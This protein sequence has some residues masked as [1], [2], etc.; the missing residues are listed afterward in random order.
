VRDN[1]YDVLIIGA[2]LSGI[3]AACHLA[4]ELPQKRVGILERRQSVGGTW[5][6][7]RY[8]GIRSDTDMLSFGYNFRP[9]N[10]LQVMG[11]GPAIRDYVAE[12]ARE[13]GVDKK[14]RFGLKT[15]RA[16]WSSAQGLW[17]VTA[18]EEG[19][20]RTLSFTAKLLMSCTGYYNYDQGYLPEFPGVETFRGQC[21]HPQHWPEGLDY[22][23]KRV[24]VIGSGATA[25][26][27]VPAMAGEAAQVTML[28]RSPSY[29]FSLPAHD[30]LTELL[31]RLLPEKL[32]FG[33]ARRRNIFLQRLIYKAAKRW[34]KQV[35]T[36]LLDGVRKNL[37]P[38]ADMSHFTPSYQPWDERL[39]AVPDADLF[40][41]IRA[42][43]ASVVTDHIETFTE[44]GIRLKSGRELEADIVI[45]ATGLQMQ[46]GGGMEFCVDGR[47]LPINEQLTYKGVLV[48]GVP[49]LAWV[50]GY[51]N[52]PWTL[53]ADLASGYVCRLLK[54]MDAQGVDVVTPRAP[55]G[56]KLD[57]SIMSSLSSGYVQ[58]GNAVLPRQ[59]RELPWRVLNHYERDRV[60]LMQ[61][62]VADAALE[63]RKTAAVARAA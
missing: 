13:Y 4:R 5:D 63:F 51:T 47:S 45:T 42:G 57:V 36:W 40:K 52:A 41:A 33:I 28:Q 26:T 8:P 50:F 53:K 39:C 17:T 14:L 35:R 49:N 30:R 16:D 59:G 19:S 61:D 3:G 2:G 38:D 21:I 11:D 6:L 54:H 20:G 58:R 32:A 55:A 12:T 56:Q 48:E 62:P 29:I 15:T 44:K 10:K 31:T 43:K 60:T 23:G 27:L 34:P 25:V 1:H 24:V 22:R 37:G 9:W 7:F 18:L 46:V